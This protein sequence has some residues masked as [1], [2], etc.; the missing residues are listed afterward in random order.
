VRFAV[1]DTGIGIPPEKQ[2]LIFE[3]FAQA[4]GSTTRR[5]GGTGLGLTISSRL[6]AMMGGRLRVDSTPDVG[7][8]FHFTIRLGRAAATPPRP[9]RPEQLHGLRVLVVDDNASNRRILEEML[10]NWHLDPLVVDRGEAALLALRRAAAE[11]NAFPLVLVDAVMPGMDGFQ[12]AEQIKRRPELAEATIMMLSSADRH[13]DATRCRE[14]G[15]ACYLTKPVK[16]SDLLDAILNQL[17]P[18]PGPAAP[19]AT[20]G[21]TAPAT[22]AAPLRVLLA[23]DNAVNQMLAIRILEKEGHTVTVAGNGKEALAHLG[24]VLPGCEQFGEA[25]DAG[26]EAAPFDLVLM[27][28][29]M[30]EMDGLEAT[31]LLRAHERGTGRRL[32][33]VAM[34]AHVMKGDREQCLAAGMDD[35]LAKPIQPAELRRVVAGFQPAGAAGEAAPEAGP[36]V[37]LLDRAAALARANHDPQLLRDLIG[38]FLDECPALLTAIREAIDRADAAALRRTAHALKG[39]VGIFGARGA[40]EAAQR[41]EGLGREGNLGDAA[42]A[43][44]ELER[45]MDVVRP[46]LAAWR[47]RPDA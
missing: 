11:G 23:E 44:A 7:S 43:Y 18:P 25:A 27:D 30:P 34:T 46:T 13:G 16:Q 22:A 2:R 8:V 36:P 20:Q 47:A 19:A 21:P 29:Q 39:S 17:A 38:V 6:V 3:P 9:L 42:D 10:R 45:T 40:Y 32:P 4:D 14:L 37:E 28:V 26:R 41:L 15:V 1:R 12:V 5:F 24:I 35:Y 33:V 31:A